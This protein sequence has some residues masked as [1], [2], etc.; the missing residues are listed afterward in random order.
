MRKYTKYTNRMH[1]VWYFPDAITI[2]ELLFQPFVPQDI[3][4]TRIHC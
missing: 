1:S 3:G 4:S 2:S